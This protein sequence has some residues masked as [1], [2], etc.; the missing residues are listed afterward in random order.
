MIVI[1]E[2]STR[3]YSMVMGN[4]NGRMAGNTKDNGN[5]VEWMV[6]ESLYLRM[7]LNMKVFMLEIIDKARAKLVGQ[8]VSIL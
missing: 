4:T 3:I 6:M 8:V 5:G 1:M 7:V 2:T